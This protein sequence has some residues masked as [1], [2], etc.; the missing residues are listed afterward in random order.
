[1][2][3][4]KVI[5]NILY[6]YPLIHA[7]QFTLVRIHILCNRKIYDPIVLI[8][9]YYISE[10]NFSFDCSYYI[11]LTWLVNFPSK[12]KI[13]LFEFPLLL[14][15]CKYLLTNL[16]WHKYL[17]NIHVV[18]LYVV[19]Y[20]FP[21]DELHLCNSQLHKRTRGTNSVSTRL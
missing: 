9:I 11:I 15:L 2:S 8:E 6:S 5:K 19:L 18:F 13:D 1:M 10:L 12:T 17:C 3:T 21:S 20:C 7:I 16:L 14:V 4:R